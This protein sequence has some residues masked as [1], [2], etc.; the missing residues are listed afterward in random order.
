MSV[1]GI[2]LCFFIDLLLL[3][4]LKRKK[5]NKQIKN[6]S[7]NTRSGNESL[8]STDRFKVSLIMRTG[9][10]FKKYT[11][12]VLQIPPSGLQTDYTCYL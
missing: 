12:L 5:I 2:I 9:L 3:S 11:C 8:M 1:G 4:T 10:D 7:A 6:N